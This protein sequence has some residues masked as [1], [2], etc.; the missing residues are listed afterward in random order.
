MVRRG[1]PWTT[2]LFHK[3]DLAASQRHESE[4]KAHAHAKKTLKPYVDQ[5]NFLYKDKVG[6][7]TAYSV[8]GKNHEEVA[9]VHVVN[10]RDNGGHFAY[11]N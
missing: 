4:A 5:G 8:V 11:K 6:D 10:D 9:T 2:H 7:V 3:G 1:M